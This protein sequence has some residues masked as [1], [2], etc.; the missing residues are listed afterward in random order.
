MKN[1]KQKDNIME[2]FEEK[3]KRPFGI[4]DKAG[5]AFGDLANNLT[6]VLVAMFMMKFYTDIMGV[7]AALVGALMMIAKVVDAFTD[8]LMGQIVERSSYTVRGKFSPWIRRFAGPVSLSCFLIFA[9]YF[10]DK[11]MGFKIFW[12]FFTYLLWGSVCYTGVNIPYG[13]MASAIS[14][15]AVDRQHLSTWRNRGMVVGQVVVVVVL[16][17]VVYT[18]NSEGNKVLNGNYVMIA[19]AVCGILAC[20]VYFACARM[21]TERIV[22]TTKRERRK[23]IFQLFGILFTNRAFIGIITASLLLLLVQLTSGGMGNYVYPNYFNNTVMLSLSSFIGSGVILVLSVFVNSLAA[24]FGK[25]ELVAF[26][27]FLGAVALILLYI[28]HTEHVAVYVILSTIASAGLGLFSLV[29][30]A[31]IT[32][33]IDDIEVKREVRSDATV[34]S[35]YS[36]A[37]K[38]GQAA[39]SGLTGLLLSFAGY[40]AA[41]AFDKSVVDKI[42]DFST[43][44]PAIGFLVIGLFL[45]LLYPLSKKAVENNASL[46]KS[47]REEKSNKYI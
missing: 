28:L 29:C 39:S 32:D 41:T 47:R 36:F 6:F 23:N 5:Y 14:D 4:R 15:K 9:P 16:P 26:G 20:S 38:L 10:A 31:M 42:Y 1:I 46:L 27:A 17:L 2:Q 37:R 45:M 18:T 40:T 8:V 3:A 13:S 22:L 7:S 25:K 43:L 24:R 30:W 12:M 33:V 21:C 19:A 11:P 34:Y 44:I 35:V